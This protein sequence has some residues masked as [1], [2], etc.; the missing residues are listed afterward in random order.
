MFVQII[1]GR[2]AQ[3]QA[4]REAAQRWVRDLAPDAAGWL[5]STVGV[6]ADGRVIALARFASEDD[7]RRNSDRPDQDK[8]WSELLSVL[9]GEPRVTESTDVAVMM[10]G[11]PDDAGFVQVIRG[12]STDPRR[13]RD[14]MTPPDDFP[15]FRP[16]VLGDLTCVTGEELITFIYFTSED[17]ARQNEKKEPPAEAQAMMDEAMKLAA[18]EPEWFDLTDPMLHSPS[19]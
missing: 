12:R 6:T 5:G 2:T 15:S 8:W 4:V 18:G 10:M 19:S 3:P 11:N 1:D 9:D 16:D 7:A 14:L 17:E 13:M